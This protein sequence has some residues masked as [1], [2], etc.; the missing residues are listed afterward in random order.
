MTH[1]WVIKLAMIGSDGFIRESPFENVLCE[2]TTICLKIMSLIIATK[3][4]TVW[5]HNQASKNFLFIGNHWSA[6]KFEIA[7]S[8]YYLN[9]RKQI[10]LTDIWAA[11]LRYQH[12]VW[13][14]FY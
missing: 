12:L 13:D 14:T 3:H 8:L 4:T 7:I 5:M 10:F 2:M 1:I 6:S 9:E 11:L